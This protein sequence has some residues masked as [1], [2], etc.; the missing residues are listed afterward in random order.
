[1]LREFKRITKKGGLVILSTP[2][3]LIKTEWSFDYLIGFLNTWS[4]VQHFIKVNNQNPVELVYNDLKKTWNTGS[5][6][7]VKF[8]ILLRI[9]KVI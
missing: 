2:N 7:E 9:G 8:P 4:A 5:V 1:M 3:F 6:K